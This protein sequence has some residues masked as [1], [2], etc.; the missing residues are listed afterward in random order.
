MEVE[1][2][3][4][5][6]TSGRPKRKCSSVQP[7]VIEPI[8]ES[9]EGEGPNGEVPSLSLPEKKPK[10]MK[11]WT[12]LR[13]SIPAEEDC[14]LSDDL[15]DCVRTL[16]QICQVPVTLTSMR[17]H[18]QGKHKLQITKYKELYG[19]FQILEHVFH[20]CH[21]CGKILL[22]D[23]DAMGGHIKGVHKMKEREYNERFMTY[24]H[25]RPSASRAD[26]SSIRKK[27]SSPKVKYD[28]KTTFPDYEYSCALKH[29]ELCDRDGAKIL[30]EHLG[31]EHTGRCDE[32][33]ELDNIPTESTIEESE[34]T[35]TVD[36]SCRIGQGGWSKKFLLT[37][38]LMG[39]HL[40]DG[41]EQSDN[42]YD[43][44]IDYSSDSIEVDSSSSES[45]EEDCAEDIESKILFE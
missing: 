39:R 28:F 24:T 15:A 16:C 12:P 18:T 13:V 27:P 43:D 1:N 20:K 14:K 2:S 26:S 38:I 31:E 11:K 35:V 45:G 8:N 5:P 32:H 19:P 17:S 41:D 23:N 36:E 40:Q 6:S 21:L 30:V 9:S 29:C 42:D 4:N 22:L 3:G 34:E 33:Y 25:S 44:S 37:D 7:S 10:Q